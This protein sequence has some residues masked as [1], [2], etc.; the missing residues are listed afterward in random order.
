MACLLQAARMT[1]GN[2][3]GVSAADKPLGNA[4]AWIIGASL[5]PAILLV[6]GLRLWR[7]KGW[8][9]GSLAALVVGLDFALLSPAPTSINAVSALVIKIALLALIVNGVRGALALQKIDY[10]NNARE[11]FG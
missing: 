4:I 2:I 9:W 5:I 8:I 10:A 11:I 1:I 6:A 7:T 3:I